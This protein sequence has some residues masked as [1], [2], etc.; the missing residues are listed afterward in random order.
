M[1]QKAEIG[2]IILRAIKCEST[3]EEQEQFARILEKKLNNHRY[4][5]NSIPL[6]RTKDKSRKITLAD[7]WGEEK[8]LV[9]L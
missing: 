1:V 2:D 3:E 5:Y 7:I 9:F 8:E 4:S 6:G